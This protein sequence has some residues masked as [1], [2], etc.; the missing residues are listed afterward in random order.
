[1]QIKWQALQCE[2]KYDQNLTDEK[3][4]H[5]LT[6]EI[7]YF[8]GTGNTLHVSEE[9]QKR[10]PD[11]TCIPI[12]GSLKSTPIK[13]SADTV[14]II[15]PIQAF[16][17]PWI[18]RRFIQNIDLSATSYLF[19]ITTRVCFTK[20]FSDIDRILAQ[21]KKS[22]DTCLSYEMP[23]N[24]IPVFNIYSPEEIEATESEMHQKLDQIAGIIQKKERC[25]PQD[26]FVWSVVSH[27]VSPLITWYFQKIRFPGM[28]KAFYA[29]SKCTGCGICEKICL[30]DKIRIT[31]GVP[32]WQDHIKCI[33]CFACLHFC[34]VQAIQ[35]HRR[36]T[37][38]RGRYHHPQ[39]TADDI[40]K[41]KEK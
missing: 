33:Y 14:G 37:Q 21:Q 2:H 24:Y 9:L 5:P 13:T 30:S 20:V 22:L 35:I 8:S 6:T 36:N 26:P 39:V 1:L 23:E 18:V 16:T 34:P 28:E 12:I 41:Q 19:A 29:D 25:Q 3:N 31:D 38:K 10:L 27:T 40:I 17:L 11:S 32:E 15:F 7:Y 4:G